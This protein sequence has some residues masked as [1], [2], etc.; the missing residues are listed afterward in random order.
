MFSRVGNFAKFF[1]IHFEK[2]WLGDDFGSILGRIFESWAVFWRLGRLLE[3]VWNEFLRL[4]SQESIKRTS[5]DDFGRTLD[6][7]WDDFG[8]RALY[9]ALRR[10]D[11]RW[12][13]RTLS[14]SSGGDGG[15][16]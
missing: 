10:R 16:V 1:R 14:Y 2:W 12:P 6:A 3:E 7:F 4:G 8:A 5:W 15:A 11:G 9:T 13:L